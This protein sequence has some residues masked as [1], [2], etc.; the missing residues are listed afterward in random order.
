MVDTTEAKWW[1]RLNGFDMFVILGGFI[2]LLVVIL[3]IG[4]WLL[5]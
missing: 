5:H 1:Q 2:N 3:L 4:Y